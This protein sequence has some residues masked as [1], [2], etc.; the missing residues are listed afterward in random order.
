MRRQSLVQHNC[1]HN[2]FLAVGVIMQSQ[3]EA[4]AA[5]EVATLKQKLEAA[6]ASMATFSRCG[7]VRLLW[8]ELAWQRGQAGT[9][10]THAN[11]LGPTCYS[12]PEPGSFEL[13]SNPC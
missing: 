2:S 1:P 12:S 8:C 5:A 13:R 4:A 3:A 7:C 6:E 10:V 9:R 11:G